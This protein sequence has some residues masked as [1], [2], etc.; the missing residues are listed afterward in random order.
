[1]NVKNIET[2]RVIYFELSN[3]CNYAYM[4]KKC[5]LYN[6]TEKIILST[7]IIKKIIKEL[8]CINYSG[9]I[10]FHN[11]NE[12]LIDP[13][14]F[15]LTKYIKSI[16]VN[17]KIGLL[18][19]GF[20]LTQDLTDE[21]YE[22]GIDVIGISLYSKEEEERLCQIQFRHIKVSFYD[23]YSNGLDNRKKI[24]ER[25]HIN[26]TLPCYSLLSEIVIRCTGDVDLCCQDWDFRHIF[27]N[28]KNT[29]LEEILSTAEVQ[30][31]RRDLKQG[32]RYL[33]LCR[34]C[35]WQRGIDYQF[36]L[37]KN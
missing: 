7:K 11:Y 21:L 4:H 37:T 31:L 9:Y 24:Y 2:L 15:Y 13:R 19:N 22:Y 36:E 12:P 28:L 23:L 32:R 16:L 17:A 30:V 27:G 20:Y 6:A 29:S 25:E 35:N 10:A 5:P 33:D 14:L 34:R 26:S 1:M 8:E 18:T 3:I